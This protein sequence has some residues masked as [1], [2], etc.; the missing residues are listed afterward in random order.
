[1]SKKFDYG[2]P[3]YLQARKEAFA[4]SGGVCQF[5]GKAEAEQAHH[6]AMRYKPPERTTGN[7]LTALCKPC[8]EIATCYRRGVRKGRLDVPKVLAAFG[9]AVREGWM[10]KYEAAGYFRSGSLTPVLPPP[11]REERPAKERIAEWMSRS[12]LSDNPRH[13]PLRGRN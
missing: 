2:H 11:K 3:A 13:S 9:W 5:C 10:T 12:K 6:W 4:R 1:M 7:D 8:H